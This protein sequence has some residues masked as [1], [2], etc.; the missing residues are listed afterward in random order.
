MLTNCNGCGQIIEISAINNHLIKECSE[1][2]LYKQCKKC[3]ES[4]HKDGYDPHVKEAK[5][6][7]AKSLSQNNRC[8]LCH[9]D[10]PPLEKGWKDHLLSK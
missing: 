4:F 8:P 9:K 7:P 1:K 3:K 10:I 2:A 5:C 6:Q